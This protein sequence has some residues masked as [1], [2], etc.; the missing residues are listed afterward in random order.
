MSWPEGVP[1]KKN[2]AT[3]A[4]AVSTTNRNATRVGT[5][6]GSDERFVD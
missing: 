5:G 3:M 1:R 6:F 2:G 4:V